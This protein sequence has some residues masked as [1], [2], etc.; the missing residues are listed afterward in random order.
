MIGRRRGKGFWVLWAAAAITFAGCGMSTEQRD[1]VI[2]GAVAGGAVG[3]GIGAGV[4]AA[5]NSDNWPA[6]PAGIVGGA[7]IGSVIGYL[8]MP[9]AAT[10]SATAAAATSSAAPTASSSGAG[11]DHPAWRAL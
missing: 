10:S 2:Y 3:G 6:L 7:I 1:C 11:K 9:A 5:D 8:D 4:F